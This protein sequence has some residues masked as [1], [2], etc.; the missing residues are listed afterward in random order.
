MATSKW[1]SRFRLL[2]WEVAGWVTNGYIAG[3]THIK[4]LK[5]GIGSDGQVVPRSLR[6]TAG[7]SLPAVGRC[8]VVGLV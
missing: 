1:V 2:P 6:R 4:E 3:S 8:L 5:I 7:N